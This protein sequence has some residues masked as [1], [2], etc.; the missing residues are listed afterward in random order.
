MTNKKIPVSEQ[1][2]GW[3][4]ASFPSDGGQTLRELQALVSKALDDRETLLKRLYEAVNNQPALN[5]LPGVQSL[6]KEV[7]SFLK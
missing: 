7:Q 1:I 6:L 3:W 5:D 4:G 2:E